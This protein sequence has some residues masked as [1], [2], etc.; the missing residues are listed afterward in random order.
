MRHRDDNP[1]QCQA[2][3]ID[4]D[5]LLAGAYFLAVFSVSRMVTTLKVHADAALYGVKDGGQNPLLS[6]SRG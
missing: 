5:A 4:L 1:V 2:Q 6:A 3:L